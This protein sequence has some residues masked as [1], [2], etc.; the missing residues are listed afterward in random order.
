MTTP[1]KTPSKRTAS[2][3]APSKTAAKTPAKP[4]AGGT[5][6][7]R[8]RV[9][10][11]L[12]FVPVVEA[13]I[14]ATPLAAGDAAAAHLARAYAAALDRPRTVAARDEVLLD[15]G[16]KLLLALRELGA[17]PHGRH[18]LV[19]ATRPPADEGDAPAG[20]ARPAAPG[21]AA[22]RAAHGRG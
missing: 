4:P 3:R 7:A 2:K 1:R 12:G 18:R 9:A 19:G 17:T 15:V 11:R 13:A 16:P 21:L 14:E 8:A 5:A 20:P 22:L 6:T 10:T